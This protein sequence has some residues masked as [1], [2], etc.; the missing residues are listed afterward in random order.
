MS[1][2]NR[3]SASLPSSKAESLPVEG[4]ISSC[5]TY[6]YTPESDVES[7][8]END[9]ENQD[10]N[11]PLAQL[12][13]ASASST[14][15]SD[16]LVELETTNVPVAEPENVAQNVSAPAQANNVPP[17]P[18]QQQQLPPG[19]SGPVEGFQLVQATGLTDTS[20]PAPKGSAIPSFATPTPLADFNMPS[21]ATAG[22]LRS[23]AGFSSSP[24]PVPPPA[25][26]AAESYNPLQEESKSK[27]FTARTDVSALVRLPC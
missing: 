5:E 1:T 27:Q 9:E 24:P 21:A 3:N 7:S 16:G 20:T 8:V 4:D 10:E 12:N 18:A 2:L 26:A 6:E 15:V 25:A 23:P 14:G 22:G 11:V 19:T 13:G 17:V